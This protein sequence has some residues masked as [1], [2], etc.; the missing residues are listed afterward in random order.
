MTSWRIGLGPVFEFERITSSRRWQSYA[1]RSCF[2]AAILLALVLVR[3]SS[4]APS[5]TQLRALA[6]MAELFFLAVSGTQLALVLLAAPAA[7][8]GAIS[9]D[10]ARGTLAHMLMTDLSDAEIVLGKLGARLVPVLSLLACMLPVMELLTLLGGVDPSALLGSFAVALGAAVLGCSLALLFSVWAGKTHE[11]LMGTYAVWA[12]WLLAGPISDLLARTGWTWAKPPRTADP[13]FL[14][15]APYWWPG[16]VVGSDYLWFLAT[17]L[18][19]S[20]LLAGIAVLRVRKVSLRDRVAKPSRRAWLDRIQQ[21][22]RS[23]YGKIL[24]LSP[25]LDDNPVLWREWHRASPSRLSV[26]IAGVFGGMSLVCSTLVMLWPGGAASAWV[27]GLQVSIGLLLLSVAAATSLA[28]ERANGS[29]ELLL[30][31]PLSR[32]QIVL[33]KWLGSF[34]TVPLIAILPVLVIE[35][36]ALQSGW[37]YCW[38]FLLMTVFV[39]AAGGVIISLGLVMAIVFSRVGRAVGMTVAIYVLVAA[40][41]LMLIG[42][43]FVGGQERGL[44][45]ASP[46][47]WAGELTFDV[48][49]RSNDIPLGWAIFWTIAWALAGAVLLRLALRQF[50]RR[51]GRIEQPVVLPAGVPRR[52]RVLQNIYLGVA[53]TL[54]LVALHPDWAPPALGFQFMLGL[55]V[56]AVTAAQT[57]WALDG[58]RERQTPGNVEPRRVFGVP[59]NTYSVVVPMI[60]PSLIAMLVHERQGDFWI[61]F[62]I[63]GL[64]MLL[65]S[66][67]FWSL[68][69]AVASWRTRNGFAI[70]FLTACW[71]LLNAGWLAL[72]GASG[73]E[74]QWWGLA[75]GM[76]CPFFAVA[77]LS[78][79]MIHDAASHDGA[80]A[81]AF[82]WSII[83][84]MCGVLL[85]R[86]ARGKS[87]GEHVELIPR[88]ALADPRSGH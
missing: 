74:S 51:L 3:Y 26:V 49:N 60:A 88:R 52:V 17:T 5:G 65:A 61:Q 58:V 18:S 34:R 63:M 66:A 59:P 30:S 50:E 37:R 53:V 33:G 25:A 71:A 2:V 27:N 22:W 36:A 70:A 55:L 78:A 24:W 13:F 29:L 80:A 87:R 28:Q 75:L 84:A 12:L 44:T 77:S 20:A 8:A 67:A 82:L 19:L 10:R 46:F 56:L 68:G 41:W 43:V 7:T 11:A 72:S 83:Y 40:G 6:K 73:G 14:A 31:T 32:E 64:Y 23:F 81:F 38:V 48:S 21:G 57:T 47:F 45:M 4:H 76:G 35:C 54:G 42:V 79:G 39:L 69:L 16:S 85:W 86:L 62:A 15:L 1:L 9:L